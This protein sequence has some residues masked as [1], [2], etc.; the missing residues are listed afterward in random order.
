MGKFSKIGDAVASAVFV[1]N[2][3]K[4]V[5]IRS[6][7]VGV[8]NRFIQLLILGY[9]IGYA[10][11][12]SKG[13]QKFDDGLSSV[14]TKVKG[15][16]QTN[17]SIDY[18]V[19]VQGKTVYRTLDQGPRTWDSAD[20]IHPAEEYDAVFVMTNMILTPV[21]VQGKCPEFGVIA[22]RCKNDSECDVG[23]VP[24]NGH[25]VMTGKCVKPDR[26]AS[27]NY[28]VCE[29][30][31]WCPVE[32]NELPMQGTNFGKR[33]TT[34]SVIFD[35]AVD[36]TIFIKNTVRFPKFGESVRNI[37]EEH[38]DPDYL[39]GCLY[40][41]DEHPLCPIFSLRTIF[42]EIPGTTFNDTALK[43]GVIA[44]KIS[45]DCNLDFDKSECVPKY[46]FVRI[47]D[48]TSKKSPG[49]NIR[50]AQYD[51][52]DITH[53]RRTL[54]KAYGIR[55]VILVD[56]QAGKFDIVPLL[57]NFGAGLGLLALATVLCDICV[58]YFLK[59]RQLYR[60]NKYLYVDPEKGENQQTENKFQDSNDNTN[61]AMFSNE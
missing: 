21:Q 31:A 4:L 41:R 13:Y 47:D 42:A 1:Y 39:K 45:W 36:F 50:I 14:T 18:P 55:F 44:I 8:M 46:S 28:S 26:P 35:E 22:A 19:T 60:D 52:S 51:I 12:Y 59:R 2:T 38:G 5:N 33:L 23:K 43:G 48:P 56:A 15:I 6:S 7:L 37:N 29:I 40:S 10:I 20:Y 9:I 58:L 11:I 30:Q 61:Y 16:A 49:Y 27:A 32:N 53:E 3:S 25:G 34:K 17:L 24:K 54:I 57:R